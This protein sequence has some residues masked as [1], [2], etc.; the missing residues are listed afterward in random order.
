[1]G[2]EAV[3]SLGSKSFKYIDYFKMIRAAVENLWTYPE[4]AVIQ[5]FSGRAIIQFTLNQT[6]QLENVRL[7]KSSGYK[8]LDDEARMAVKS[9]APYKPFPATLDK[10]RLHIVAT[11]VYQPTF[12]AVR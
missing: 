2:D 1:M 8:S 5:G 7:I 12:S 9:A 11:F 6:G 3:V 10:K 4:E